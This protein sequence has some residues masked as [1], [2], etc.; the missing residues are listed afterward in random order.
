MHSSVWDRLTRNGA[1]LNPPSV[2]SVENH[3]AYQIV[4]VLC[5]VHLLQSDSLLP[6]VDDHI[7]GALG[8]D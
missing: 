3:C 4:G 8:Q 6:C 5:L 2:G 1:E 7:L